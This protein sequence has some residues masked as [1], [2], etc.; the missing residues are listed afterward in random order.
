MKL[1]SLKKSGAPGGRPGH[2]SGNNKTPTHRSGQGF[3]VVVLDSTLYALAKAQAFQTGLPN[4]S[5]D[6]VPN[7]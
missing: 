5:W 4:A 3:C 6:I 2:S 1:A 7:G